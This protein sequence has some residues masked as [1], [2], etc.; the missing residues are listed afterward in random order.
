MSDFIEQIKNDTEDRANYIGDP[1]E[2]LREN[3]YRR[4]EGLDE[5]PAQHEQESNWM[6]LPKLPAGWRGWLIERLSKDWVYAVRFAAY[7]TAQANREAL[8]DAKAAA[9]S[10]PLTGLANRRLFNIE[11][12]AQLARA[13]RDGRDLVGLLYIDVD[14]FKEINTAHGHD[15]GD[16]L[17]CQL[18]DLLKRVTRAGDVVARL[19]GDEFAVML[20]GVTAISDATTVADKILAGMAEWD[21]SASIGVAV[22]VDLPADMI[23]AADT[24]SQAAKD[25]GKATWRVSIR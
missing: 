21:T 18:G 9:L 23:I 25:A 11:L 17:L 16:Q 22:G 24:A 15:G 3:V 13:R 10:D 8:K 6:T 12:E 2:L 14:Y 4:A 20:T 5:I 19:G 7:K 1:G